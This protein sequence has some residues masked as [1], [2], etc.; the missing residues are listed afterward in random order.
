MGTV[1]NLRDSSVSLM[2]RIIL[3]QKHQNKLFYS[4]SFLAKRFFSSETKAFDIF[5]N[6]S[7]DTVENIRKPPKI[8]AQK[9]YNL[10]VQKTIVS[11]Y[12]SLPSPLNS[13]RLLRRKSPVQELLKHLEN[14]T[15][16]EINIHRK[17]PLVSHLRF[18]R[19]KRIYRE[20]YKEV[21]VQGA[22]TISSLESEVR[23]QL[24]LT[25]DQSRLETANAEVVL[26][27]SEDL[28]NFICDLEYERK[29]VDNDTSSTPKVPEIGVLPLP[30][31]DEEVVGTSRFILALDH[32]VI[33]DNVGRALLTARACGVGGVICTD[34]TA[35]LF[36]WKTLESSGGLSYVMPSVVLS[37]GG[38]EIV[39]FCEKHN[40]L[41]FVADKRGESVHSVVKKIAQESEAVEDEEAKLFMNRSICLVIG[42][43]SKGPSEEV[44][45]RLKKISMP[46]SEMVESLNVNVAASL[47]L[48]H[49]RR[50]IGKLFNPA[51]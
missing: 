31:H 37:G 28:L 38:S 13:P 4:A 18:L 24:I 10:G 32:L 49:L 21:F 22:H 47:I 8:A 33:P 42:N 46:Q 23:F 17:S 25:S 16:D 14:N 7:D 39:G 35:D 11:N 12:E 36:N 9:F 40:A 3:R 29:G 15:M 1:Y 20:E 48:F 5:D 30:Q 34:R 44:L 51:I 27:V 45:A 6:S 50:N 43:E 2:H 41:G 19:R 26:F